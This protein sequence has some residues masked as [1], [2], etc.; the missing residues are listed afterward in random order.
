MRGFRVI[1]VLVISILFSMSAHSLEW[2][3]GD[4]SSRVAW[5]AKAAFGGTAYANN[6][7]LPS[8]G[9]TTSLNYDAWYGNQDYAYSDSYALQ[10]ASYEAGGGQWVGPLGYYDGVRYRGGEC[11]FF[12][13]LVLYRSS[14]WVGNGT[15]LTTMS[16]SVYTEDSS[17][18]VTRTWSNV[19]PGWILISPSTPHMGV[20][21]SRAYVK[22]LGTNGSYSWGW[23]IIDSN[24]VGNTTSDSP[25]Y[26][27]MIGRHFMSDTYLSSKGYFA[28][29][30]HLARAN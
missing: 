13:R 24:F 11:T 9:K 23:W 18:Y 29:R 4:W 1:V 10:M 22:T 17:A 7:T 2:S 5:E 21:I 14:Y 27:H 20:A 16:P 8:A 30:P 15:H 28:W 19:Q 3:G 6:G 25:K 12:V 26:T